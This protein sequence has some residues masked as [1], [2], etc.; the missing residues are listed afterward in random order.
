MY[1]MQ[2]SLYDEECDTM[3]R[4]AMLMILA[5]WVCSSFISFPAIAW[6]RSTAAG[7]RRSAL[8]E[9]ANAT[10]SLKITSVVV[11]SYSLH[12]TL[13]KNVQN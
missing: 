2:Q 7:K 9:K 4:R 11:S 5:I 1:L 3:C 13:L 10:L 6:W 12:C 8:L